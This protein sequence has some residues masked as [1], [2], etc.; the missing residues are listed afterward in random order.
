MS[1]HVRHP[2]N[3]PLRH[4]RSKMTKSVFDTP[5]V[6][7]SQT[8]G[9][10]DCDRGNSQFSDEISGKLTRTSSH[11]RHH[12]NT[13]LGDEESEMT[14]SVF[15]TPVKNKSQTGE[16]SGCDH[17]NSQFPR[18]QYIRVGTLVRRSERDQRSHID[19]KAIIDKIIKDRKNTSESRIFPKIKNLIPTHLI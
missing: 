6:H 13:S 19:F 1:S 7:K 10:S 12:V 17:E 14:K 5:M 18:F 3:T 2:D 8:G 11:T 9:K 16:K 15:D 4:K